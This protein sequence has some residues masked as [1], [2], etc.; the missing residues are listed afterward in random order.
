MRV[1]ELIAREWGRLVGFV[2]SWIEDTAE[3][4]AVDLV[5]DVLAGFFERADVTEPIANLSAYLYRSLRNRVVDE[6]RARSGK[7]GRDSRGLI[8]AIVDPR[9]E[10]TGGLE[11]V[12]SREELFAALDRLPSAQR[13]VVFATALEGKSYG[14]LSEQWGIPVG[15]LLARKHRGIRSLRRMLEGGTQ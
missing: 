2:R 6:Y 15:T 3:M 8:A 4:E 9:S 14:E 11:Q 10:V 7:P 5:Q 13:D 12:E 1:S